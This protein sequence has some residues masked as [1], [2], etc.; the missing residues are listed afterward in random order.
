[1]KY[2][3][4]RMVPVSQC[5]YGVSIIDIVQVTVRVDRICGELINGTL[6]LM[7]CLTIYNQSAVFPQSS[8]M[9][10]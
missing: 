9:V 6:L 8:I 2:S 1:V 5:D 3:A 10:K 7:N 4:Y